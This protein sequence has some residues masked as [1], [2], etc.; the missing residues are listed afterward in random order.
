MPKVDEVRVKDINIK[1]LFS[2]EFKWGNR[3]YFV[4]LLPYKDR[5]RLALFCAKKAVSL[6]DDPVLYDL[7]KNSNKTIENFLEGKASIE[8]CQIAVL[9]INNYILLSSATVDSYAA[10]A[11]SKA[12]LSPMYVESEIGANE[13][14][15]A[16]VHAV[17]AIETIYDDNTI[18]EEIMAYLRELIITNISKEE[19]AANWLLIASL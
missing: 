11:R 12:A 2:F 5:V 14:C 6:I 3:F 8:Q 18:K 17:T 1:D 9:Q 15:L 19:R 16:V 4:A 7:C 10:I 13:V